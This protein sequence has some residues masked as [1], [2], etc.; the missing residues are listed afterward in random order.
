VIV[1]SAIV[2]IG[3]AELLPSL[4]QR[5]RPPA[6]GAS[7]HSFTSDQST[8]ALDFIRRHRPPVVALEREFSSSPP[9]IVFL[10]R[11]KKDPSLAE[12]DVRIVAVESTTTAAT[13]SRKKSGSA[14][15]VAK[16]ESP[17][18]TVKPTINGTRRVPRVRISENVSVT[19][20]GNP[21][22]LVD[23]SAQG[24]Q[25]LSPVVLRPNQ[26]VRLAFSEDDGSVRCA[27]AVQWASF[28]MPVGQP[29]RYRA[30]VRFSSDVDALAG[31]AERHKADR[32]GSD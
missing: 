1:V 16:T 20:D 25:V 6:K 30:G 15:A 26:R 21:A 4:S 22:V 3:P 13:T 32:N 23:L 27:G 14:I 17:A 19:V 18:A 12:C 9:G 10:R 8:Q 2:L 24:A 28:E 11:M 7:F 29:P 5:V 31:Y